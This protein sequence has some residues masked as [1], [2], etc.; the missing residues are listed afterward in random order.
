MHTG[1]AAAHL[2]PFSLMMMHFIHRRD[3][4]LVYLAKESG[5]LAQITKAFRRL[6][7]GLWLSRDDEICQMLET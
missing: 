4:K 3:D 6:S 5:L 2:A 1:K 7:E